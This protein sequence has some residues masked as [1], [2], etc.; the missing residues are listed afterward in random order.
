MLI[1]NLRTS[2]EVWRTENTGEGELIWSGQS[3]RLSKVRYFILSDAE[4]NTSR[5]L[6]RAG[7]ADLPLL[8][9]LLAICQKFLVFGK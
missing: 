7:I 9:T 2:Q 6:N 3:A 1:V 8:R 5:P 4:G